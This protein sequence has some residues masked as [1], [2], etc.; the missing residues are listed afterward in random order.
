MPTKRVFIN[1]VTP[2]MF[3]LND[4]ELE[5]EFE[6]QE[7]SLYQIREIKSNLKITELPYPLPINKEL[8]FN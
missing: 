3:N 6:D 5:E 7:E 8:H 1:R 2:E 4:E